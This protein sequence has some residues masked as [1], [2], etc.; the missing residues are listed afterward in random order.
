MRKFLSAALI[1]L[2]AVSVIEAQLLP[3]PPVPVSPLNNAVN[4]QLTPVLKWNIVLIIGSLSS[5]RL[6]VS[7]N[8]NFSNIILDSAGIIM[9]SLK[10]PTGILESNTQYYWR[11]NA[12]VLVSSILLT[13]SF[14]T[15]FRFT[16]GSFTG[17]QQIST[18][19]PPVYRLYDNYPN[20]FNPTTKIRFEN[21]SNSVVNLTVYD[22]LG[23]KVEELVNE[24][25]NAGVYE[26]GWNAAAYSSGI[27]FYRLSAQN[28]T[29]T[30]KMILTK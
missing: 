24:N 13:T 15:A 20:P 17:I 18:E 22:I 10:I 7:T 23:K 27:Y 30:K 28:Y 8:Q 21:A 3:I 2:F 14:S 5:F 29:E 26:T 11:V 16:T 6:Q 12:S 4:I 19:I 9:D 1:I 25:L